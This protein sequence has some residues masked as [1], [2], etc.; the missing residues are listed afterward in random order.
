[1][2]VWFEG[3]I[4][5]KQSIARLSEQSGYSERTLKRYFYKLLPRCPQ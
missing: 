4:L 3:W 2:F 5:G 1:M